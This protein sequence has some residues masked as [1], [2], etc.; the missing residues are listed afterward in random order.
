MSR[1][2]V[3]L[4]QK[5]AM[6]ADEISRSVNRQLAESG[7]PA[8]YVLHQNRRTGSVYVK[9]RVYRPDGRRIKGGGV[10][11]RVS[12]HLDVES[13]R[14]NFSQP[15]HRYYGISSD[16]PPKRVAEKVNVIVHDILDR[17]AKNQ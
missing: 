7:Q 6:F 12:N 5:I 15:A 3:V 14:V 11:I 2:N 9:I 13:H 1:E 16:A 4:C 17:L 10:G 8:R